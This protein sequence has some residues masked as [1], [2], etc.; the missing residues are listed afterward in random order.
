VSEL[1][2]KDGVPI[3]ADFAGHEPPLVENFDTGALYTINEAGVVQRVGAGDA[4]RGATWVSG[5]SA[6]TV[7]VNDVHVLVPEASTIHSATLLTVGGTGSC[8]V[9]VRK[10]TYG[11]FPPTGGDT[12]CGGSKPT[13]SS[14]IKYQ[15]TTLTGWTTAVAAG[16]V[17]SFS[18][19][20]CSTFT[21][22]SLQLDMR[23]T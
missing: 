12:I 11:A 16:S 10:D 17:L 19:E 18:L 7:P 15:D 20:S 4:V 2:V 21:M 6:I 9:D 23:N 13:I 5:G 3:A 1:R 8:V 14:G 22:V